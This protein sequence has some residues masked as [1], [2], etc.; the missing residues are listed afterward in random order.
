MNRKDREYLITK[1]GTLDG[2]WLD[3]QI[4]AFWDADAAAYETGDSY[5]SVWPAPW[6]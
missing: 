3:K 4:R 6:T 1:Y 2:D 5:E